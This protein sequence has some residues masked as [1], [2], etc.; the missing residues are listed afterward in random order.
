MIKRITSSDRVLEDLTISYRKDVAPA[1]AVQWAD[2]LGKFPYLV[3]SYLDK[4]ALEAKDIIY[5]KLYG[6]RYI[7]EMECT[8]RDP[9]NKLADYMFPLDKSIVS[10]MIKANSEN[11]MPIRCDFY[12]NNFNLVK[13]GT[14]DDK[15]YTMKCILDLP[16]VIKNSSFSKMSSFNVL[17]QISS[18]TLL[19]FVSN[20]DDTND[21]MTWINPGEDVI[22]EFIPE[23]VVPYSYKS[24]DSFLWSFIDYYYNLNYI[25][26]ETALNEDTTNQQTILNSKDISGSETTIPLVLSNHPDKRS[27]NLYIDRWNLDNDSTDINIDISYEPWIYYI[28]DLKQNFVQLLLDTI[29]TAGEDKSSIVLKQRNDSVNT[30]VVNSQQKKKYYLGRLDTDNAHKNLLYAEKQNE[31][32]ILSLQKIKINVILPNPNFSLYRFQLVDVVIYDLNDMETKKGKDDHDVNQVYA[33]QNKINN[34]LSGK[35]LITGINWVMDRANVKGGGQSVFVQEI[36]MV[37]RELTTL[38]QPK[39]LTT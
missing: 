9:T 24:D 12:I 14:R 3:F 39:K 16:I 18:E 22:R 28:D 26:I 30:N 19:G 20:I 11:L 8:F 36:T 1:D 37:R 27:S 35:W 25:E 32:N 21:I 15:I 34:R 38:Y 13:G 17:K 10:L 29:S 5:F 4:L 7:P 2:D 6:D 33:N 23:E 31:N